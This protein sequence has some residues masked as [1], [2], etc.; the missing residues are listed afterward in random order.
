[1]KHWG[2]QQ[3]DEPKKL[4]SSGWLKRSGC[5]SSGAPLCAPPPRAVR[6]RHM[7]P[8]SAGGGACAPSDPADPC[9]RPRA[10]DWPKPPDRS[11]TLKAHLIKSYGDNLVQFADRLQCELRAVA[12]ADPASSAAACQR[13]VLRAAVCFGCAM[14]AH[15]ATVA[16]PQDGGAAGQDG[17]AA[18][19]AG[20]VA[21]IANPTSAP[22]HAAAE[23]SAVATWKAYRFRVGLYPPEAGAAGSVAPALAPATVPTLVAMGVTA[24]QSP[25]LL[26]ANALTASQELSTYA[27]ALPLSVQPGD[28]SRLAAAMSNLVAAVGSMMGGPTAAETSADDR[29][30]VAQGEHDRVVATKERAAMALEGV[31]LAEA[32]PTTQHAAAKLRG[33]AKAMTRAAKALEGAYVARDWTA[34]LA[35]DPCGR[36][37]DT[38]LRALECIAADLAEGANA[39]EH[40]YAQ[41]RRTIQ[42]GA[43]CDECNRAMAL[44]RATTERDLRHS[45]RQ[46]GDGGA[47]GA[48]GATRVV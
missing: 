41:W 25:Q 16:N 17:G 42:E 46:N 24:T 11:R 13:V 38:R 35:R 2:R 7:A 12:S 33:V 10:P 5:A 1:V 4:Q 44:A 3:V 30:H 6:T 8:T 34:P 22:L 19:Q 43:E 32:P 29:A 40:G 36:S 28:L 39:L 21:G 26:L 9:D 27:A 18:G 47:R 37:L 20:V 14:H 15:L 48:G 45:L 31:Y 23:S